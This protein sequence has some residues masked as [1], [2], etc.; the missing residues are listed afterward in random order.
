M[1]K[2]IIIFLFMFLTYFTLNSVNTYAST[3]DYNSF[4]EIIMNEGK[5]LSNFTAKEYEELYAK[6]T[7]GKML[8]YVVYVE[9]NNV[10]AT[11]ISNTLYSIENNLYHIL[12]LYQP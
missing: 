6:I 8:G 10:D 1:E 5:L 11:Y 12:L 2:K 9:N 4:V 7:S 3:D